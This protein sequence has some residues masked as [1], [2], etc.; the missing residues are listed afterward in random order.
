MAES[1]ANMERRKSLT[2]E[3]RLEEH[4]EKLSSVLKRRPNTLL[5]LQFTPEPVFR[6]AP[7][8][9]A[10]MSMVPPITA[11]TPKVEIN[12]VS[13]SSGIANPH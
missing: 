11:T 5:A 10:G 13:H 7:M 4:G 1:S 8:S 12:T 6:R 3:E 9:C 2:P